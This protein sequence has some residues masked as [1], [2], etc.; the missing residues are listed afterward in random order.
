[1]LIIKIG[2]TYMN[3]LQ[4]ELSP[5]L[6]RWAKDAVDWYPWGR[7]AF[8]RAANE[9]KPMLITIGTTPC[10][11]SLRCD[12]GTVA[13][14]TERYFIPVQVDGQEHPD[15]AAVYRRASSLLTGRSGAALEVLTDSS[16]SPFFASGAL[17]EV[18]LA[19]LLSGVA[20]HWNSDPTDYE[21]T[22][23]LM[24]ER[25][26]A[27]GSV[28]SDGLPAGELWENHFAYLQSQYDET[29]GGFG[30]EGKRLQPH[31]LLFLLAYG[32]YTGEPLPIRMA[33]QTLHAMA[34]GAVRDQIGGGFFHG[35]TDARWELPIPEKR[36]ID[37]AWLLDAYTRAWELTGTELFRRVAAETADFAIRELRHA[38]G[39]FYTAQWSEDGFYEL[40]DAEVRRVLGDNDG[41]VFCRQY[42]IGETPAAPHLFN[43]D[44]PAE[45]SLLLHDGRM[46]LYRYRL[47]RS[48]P[49]RDDKVLTGHNGVMIA[50]LA[51]AGRVLGV[52]RYLT[53]AANAEEFLRSRLVTPTDLRRYWCHGGVAGDGAL[54]DYAGY[55]M[56]LYALYRCGC[57]GEYLRHA[58]KVMARADALFSDHEDGGYFLT[59]G[60]QNLPVRPKQLWDGSVPSGWSV[61]LMTLAG[62]SRE[63]PYPGLRSRTGELMDYAARA[64][65][66]CRCGYAL[67]AMLAAGGK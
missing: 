44:D 46:K 40:T 63:I 49:Q 57:G 1:M 2:G 55:A 43:G 13:R 21:Q 9:H 31:E 4:G 23:A 62:L 61:A 6:N 56:G 12:K 45:D 64:A 67:T 59:R 11:S 36:L 20:L 66:G 51:R 26:S 50:A 7:E 37:Q 34:L 5:Y 27:T 10:Q 25:L 48:E 54:E 3:R 42:S 28:A 52:E 35:T 53:A 39:G 41:S 15:V 58:A 22:A 14:L 8:A 47:Q 18:E 60:Q 32:K 33:E 16:G 17:R 38:A 19:G 65:R 29:N 30:S 24:R